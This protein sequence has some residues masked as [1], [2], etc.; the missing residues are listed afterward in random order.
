M[1]VK[2]LL[3]KYK[4]GKGGPGGKYSPLIPKAVKYPQNVAKQ[5]KVNYSNVIGVVKKGNSSGST[6]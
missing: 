3:K 4:D 1:I 5:L 2:K 6:I